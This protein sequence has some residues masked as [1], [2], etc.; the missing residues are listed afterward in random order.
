MPA[1]SPIGI[2]LITIV[3]RMVHVLY[4]L[5]SSCRWEPSPA[6]GEFSPGICIITGVRSSHRIYR[7]GDKPRPSIFITCPFQSGMVAVAS[8]VA[9]GSRSHIL[10]CAMFFLFLRSSSPAWIEVFASVQG[11]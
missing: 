4:C 9:H 7:P 2:T 11:F 10:L 1:P 6:P 8:V 5:P 3:A